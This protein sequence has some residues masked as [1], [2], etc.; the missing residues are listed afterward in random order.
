[1]GASRLRLGGRL[2]AGM[3]GIML[4]LPLS[5]ADAPP[6]LQPLLER[7]AQI[8]ADFAAQAAKCAS[9]T[10]TGHHAFKGCID[11]HSAVHGVWALVAYERASGDRRY[12]PLVAALLTEEAIE[13]ERDLLRRSPAFEMPYGRAWFLRLAMEHH[14]LTGASGLL[15]MADDVAASLRGYFRRTGINPLSGSYGSAS[16]ALINFIDYTDYRG[17]AAMRE[18]AGQWV[19]E[20]FIL[21]GLRCPHHLERG[22]FMAICTN[23]AALAARVLDRDD[24]IGWLDKFIAINGIPAPVKQAESAHHYGLNFS[25]AWGLWDIYAKSGRPD[26][27]EAYVKHLEHGLTP[28]SNWRGDYRTVGHW[29]AQFG[30]FALQPLFGPRIGV[31]P[32]GAAPR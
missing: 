13:Q 10:D 3:L 9:R 20:K 30:M 12:T 21:A 29:V 22:H 24:Y 31:K 32:H 4:T 7:K 16:W 25:R 2:F 5:A 18:E 19:R 14:A 1:M 15:D 27:M 26:I 6:V 8:A 23:W 17:L 11:W 28:A